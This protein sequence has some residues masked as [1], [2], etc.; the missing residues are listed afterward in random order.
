MSKLTVTIDGQPFDVGVALTPK[1]GTECLVMINGS[2]V[3]IVIPDLADPGSALEWIIVDGRT[4][5]LTVDKDLQWLK[6]YSGLHRVE[7]HDS[8]ATMMRPVSGDGRIKAPIPG[9]ISRVLVE[10]GQKVK[11]NQALFILEAMKMENELRAPFDGIVK[12]LSVEQGQ[13]VAQ[14]DVLLRLTTHD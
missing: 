3:P 9:L 8:E 4:Y 11:A 2:A 14:N 6:A 10:A 13:S 5:E 1:C 12:S 7:I